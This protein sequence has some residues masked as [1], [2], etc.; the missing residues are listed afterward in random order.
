MRLLAERNRNLF[1]YCFTMPLR[2]LLVVA[3]VLILGGPS[4]A[5]QLASQLRAQKTVNVPICIVGAGPGGLQ[6]AHSLAGNG[7]HDFLVFERT[8]T[9]GSYFVSY[10]RHRRLISLNKRFTG[11]SNPEFNLRHDWQVPGP[12]ANLSR[13]H[14]CIPRR[15]RR[16]EI[17]R[18]RRFQPSWLDPYPRLART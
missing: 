11:R 17:L 14:P 12:A 8:H 6:V 13:T 10:P 4:S 1:H 15:R 7:S 5:S 16:R 9:P 3:A 2:C 18:L